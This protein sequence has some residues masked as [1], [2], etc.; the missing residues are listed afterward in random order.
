[1]CDRGKHAGGGT[2]GRGEGGGEGAAEGGACP[3]EGGWDKYNRACP[4]RDWV[5]EDVGDDVVRE[6][7]SKRRGGGWEI[8]DVCSE[9]LGQVLFFFLAC[10]TSTTNK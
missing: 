2:T 6:E 3:G 1:M 9:E 8:L 10:F 7:V 5:A 4:R